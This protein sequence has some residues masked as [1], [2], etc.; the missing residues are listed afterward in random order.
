MAESKES[1]GTAA[2]NMII[3][4]VLLLVGGSMVDST[5]AVIGF[6]ASSGVSIESIGNYGNKK[7]CER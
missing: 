1:Y 3:L 4:P 7:C 2:S 6:V 5:K